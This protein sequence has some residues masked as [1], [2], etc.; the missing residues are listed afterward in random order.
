MTRSGEEQCV[1]CLLPSPLECS[2]HPGRLQGRGGRHRVRPKELLLPPEGPCHLTGVYPGC[3][4][5]PQRPVAGCVG[6]GVCWSEHQ[7]EAGPP[8][9]TALKSGG[10][11]NNRIHHTARHYW[12]CEGTDT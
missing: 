2:V 5:A 7:P 4:P 10:Q 11:R 12:L 8:G 6:P 9:Q 1:S 3:L